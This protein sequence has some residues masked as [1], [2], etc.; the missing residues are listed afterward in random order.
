MG[1]KKSIG[2]ALVLTFLFGPLGMLYCTVTGFIVMFLVNI[3]ALF[4]TMGFGLLFTWPICMIWAVIAVND[5]N[6]S[7]QNS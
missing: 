3:L 5:Y 4:F 2:A 1:N 7:I 6:S